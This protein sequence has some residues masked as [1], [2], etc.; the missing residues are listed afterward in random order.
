M[1][2]NWKT[3]LPDA[4]E[5]SLRKDFLAGLISLNEYLEATGMTPLPP[6][7]GDVFYVPEGQQRIHKDDLEKLL[8]LRGIEPQVIEGIVK[9]V[10]GESD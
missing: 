1:G 10:K 3:N 8:L 5:E 7:E 2:D 9:R 6:E 4:Y